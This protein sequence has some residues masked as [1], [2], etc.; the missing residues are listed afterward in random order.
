MV[1]LLVLLAVL[2]AIPQRRARSALFLESDTAL[3]SFIADALTAE[4]LPMT[5]IAG[6][7]N[8]TVRH[9]HCHGSAFAKQEQFAR[10]FQRVGG[11]GRCVVK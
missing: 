9:C 3:T 7:P 6:L 4:L 5:P 2:L 10:E 8:R 11:E 1:L